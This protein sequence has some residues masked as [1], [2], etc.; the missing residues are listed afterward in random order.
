MTERKILNIREMPKKVAAKVELLL[1]K[2][3]TISD[4]F[5][6]GSKQGERFAFDYGSTSG[7]MGKMV[8]GSNFFVIGMTIVDDDAPQLGRHMVSSIWMQMH[9]PQLKQGEFWSFVEDWLDEESNI[10]LISAYADAYCMTVASHW[11][12]KE[13]EKHEA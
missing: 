12:Q 10:Q 13:I 7:S 1:A 2:L 11:M 8:P 9:P 6:S 3:N 5:F 4:M